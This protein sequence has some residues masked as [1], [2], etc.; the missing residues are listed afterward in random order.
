MIT[1]VR[2][3]THSTILMA[4][5]KSLHSNTST[6]FN[7]NCIVLHFMQESQNP[8][9]QATACDAILSFSSSWKSRQEEKSEL[10]VFLL[11]MTSSLYLQYLYAFSVIPMSSMDEK[12]LTQQPPTATNCPYTELVKSLVRKTIAILNNYYCFL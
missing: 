11:R 4:S 6:S 5:F 3:C 2:T 7:A 12:E 10:I 9:R 8:P 1:L